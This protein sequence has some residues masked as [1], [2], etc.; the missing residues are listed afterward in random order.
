MD[1]K[2]GTLAVQLSG[3][4]GE[5]GHGPQDD[6]ETNVHGHG[7]RGGVHLRES[8]KP[9]SAAGAVRVTSVGHP[10]QLEPEKFHWTNC[11]EVVTFELC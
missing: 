9:S 1:F 8:E 11:L 6:P 4:T 10:I 5:D 7:W 2:W 3:A